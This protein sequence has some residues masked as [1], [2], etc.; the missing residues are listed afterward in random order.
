LDAGWKLGL[1]D[2]LFIAAAAAGVVL[3]ALICL[4]SLASL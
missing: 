3:I 1:E 4:E 2:V